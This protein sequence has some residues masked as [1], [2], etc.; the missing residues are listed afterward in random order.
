MFSPYTLSMVDDN[1][2]S[3][4]G[5]IFFSHLRALSRIPPEGGIRDSCL[6]VCSCQDFSRGVP[7]VPPVKFQQF[8]KLF[9]FKTRQERRK[10]ENSWNSKSC[11]IVRDR[12]C[13]LCLASRSWMGTKKESR[14]HA[15]PPTHRSMNS[16]VLYFCKLQGSFYKTKCH[17]SSSFSKSLFMERKNNSGCDFLHWLCGDRE[18]HLQAQRSSQQIPGKSQGLCPPRK[19]TKFFL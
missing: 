10:H 3:M 14:S 12:F 5:E 6:C 4:G 7:T 17:P 9:L 19:R 2:D 8:G 16:H 1:G 13:A 15:L 11:T 18:K